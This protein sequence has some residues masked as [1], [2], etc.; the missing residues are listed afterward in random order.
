MIHKLIQ[1]IDP[2]VKNYHGETPLHLCVRDCDL[3]DVL[4]QRGADPNVQDGDGDTPLYRA[5][6]IGNTCV[7]FF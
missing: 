1:T 2:N 3:V 6:R 5:A 7:K 4:L